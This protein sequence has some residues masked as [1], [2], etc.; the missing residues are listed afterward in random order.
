LIK[1]IVAGLAVGGI[2]FA[3]ALGYNVWP[4][5]L[6]G[7]VGVVLWQVMGSRGMLRTARIGVGAPPA[8]AAITFDDIGGQETAK[9]ELQEAL[10]FL[11]NREHSRHLGIR[12]LRGILLAGP[13]GTGKTLLARAAA[14]FT[15]SAFISAA[16]SEFVEVYAGVGAQRVRDLFQ[17][18]REH[19]RRQD[20]GKAIVF[21]DEIEVLGGARGKHSSHLEYDQTLN[22]LLVEMDGL[23]TAAADADIL[24]VGATNRMDLLDPALLRPGRFDRVVKVDLPD[25][26]GR[27]S[28]LRLHMRNKPLADDVDLELSARET[29]GF[30]GAHLE[31]LANEAAIMALREDSPVIT[32]RHLLEAIDKVMLGERLPRRPSPEEMRRI[33]IHETGHALVAERVRPNSVATISVSSRGNALGYV[34]QIPRDDAY[35]ETH[36]EIEEQVQLLLAGAVAEELMLGQWSTGAS[37]D[38][39][40]AAN[41]ARRLVCAG[42]SPL[43]FVDAQTLPDTLMHRAVS[44]VLREQEARARR[45]LAGVR[46][47]ID[48]VAGRL[49][50]D[51]TVDGDEL[52][53]LLTEAAGSDE[54]DEES[55][56]LEGLS[57]PR[58]CRADD[59]PAAADHGAKGGAA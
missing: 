24:V 9:R 20:G 49:V 38:L 58:G 32:Q 6:L 39:D 53:R 40:Q 46:A 14:S 57:A 28:I 29:F 15:H 21:I 16:G 19:T 50:E 47:V 22:Q 48:R 45:T 27:L 23:G 5:F 41:L 37:Q 42:M 4:V 11:C 13:P 17:R 25:R 56:S 10:Q 30:S 1:E 36:G 33:A 7:L 35:L 3:V 18:A 55:M 44:R 52:R 51:E 43:R 26:V 34:R 2:V 12:P 54:G 8:R 31:S 59:V